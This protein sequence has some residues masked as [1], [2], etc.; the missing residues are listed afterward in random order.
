MSDE[1]PIDLQQKAVQKVQ[2]FFARE[3]V[4]ESMLRISL[5]Q[6][7]CMGGRGYAYGLQAENAP[8]ESDLILEVQGLPVILRKDDVPRMKGAVID[9]VE[10][11][12]GSGF[13]VDNPNTI[14]KCPCGHHDLFE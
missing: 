5:V 10:G 14:G 6:T 1:G 7:H 8:T 3:G 2:E 13:T 4:E 11:L 12:G 9:Y